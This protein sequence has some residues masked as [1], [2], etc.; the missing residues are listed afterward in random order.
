VRLTGREMTEL[1]ERVAVPNPGA[2]VLVALGA[3]ML[4][5]VG[6]VRGRRR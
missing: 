5:G 3:L 2:A 6:L 4:T 1:K